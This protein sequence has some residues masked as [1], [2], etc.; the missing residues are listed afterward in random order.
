[1][2]E[3]FKWVLII[4]L[5]VLTCPFLLLLCGAIVVILELLIALFIIGLPFIIPTIAV[6]SIV[7]YF[8][9]RL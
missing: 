2:K 9:E 5:A 7:D 8:D 6:W 1:M 3:F 4:L